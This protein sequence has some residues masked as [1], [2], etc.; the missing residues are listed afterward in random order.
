MN[1][2]LE[3]HLIEWIHD[4]RSNG[5]RVSRK[6][7]RKKAKAMFDEQCKENDQYEELFNATT[8]W[9]CRFMKRYGLSLQRK[10]I[11]SQHDPVNLIDKLISCV[12]LTSGE[13]RNNMPPKLNI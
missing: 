3:E 8:G 2:V 6:L 1:E 9:L 4:R 13:F 10:T 7:I 11:I 5:L 12:L